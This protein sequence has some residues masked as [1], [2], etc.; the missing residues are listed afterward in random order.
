MEAGYH[1]QNPTKNTCVLRWAG[2]LILFCFS[3]E[4]DKAARSP[5]RASLTNG[6]DGVS[7]LCLNLGGGGVR[8]SGIKMIL[9]VFVKPVDVLLTNKWLFL[10]KLVSILG[11]QVLV[12][13]LL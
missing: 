11:I 5:I 9:R 1:F 2:L 13:H 3:V 8:A 7:P 4:A 6:C 12:S 10:K